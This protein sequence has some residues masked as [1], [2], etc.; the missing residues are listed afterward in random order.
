MSAFRNGRWT[1]TALP[2]P[3]S[4]QAGF[5]T[6]SPRRAES[7]RGSSGLRAQ[8]A[9]FEWT[10]PGG[11]WPPRSL[12][13]IRES[14]SRP[15]LRL[16]VRCRSRS[17]CRSREGRAL[18]DDQEKSSPQRA[19]IRCSPVP[20]PRL[21]VPKEQPPFAVRTNHLVRVLGASPT[22]STSDG[23]DAATHEASPVFV[24]AGTS[25]S[26]PVLTS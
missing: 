18:Q 26:R 20:C 3:P 8:A 13:R 21:P 15:S 12:Y 22:S 2:N 7:W 23:R 10:S 25:T 16:R 14:E 9:A 4:G 11:R 5:T 17:V 19:S 24:A 6:D 1:D